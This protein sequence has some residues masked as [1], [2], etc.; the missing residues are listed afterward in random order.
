MAD[1]LNISTPT[2]GNTQTQFFVKMTKDG[3]VIE[4]S[5]V[6]T[7]KQELDQSTMELEYIPQAPTEQEK[8]NYALGLPEIAGLPISDDLKKQV[9]E[10]YILKPD[11]EMPVFDPNKSRVHADPEYFFKTPCVPVIWT[12]KTGTL[13]EAVSE[14]EAYRQKMLRSGKWDLVVTVYKQQY[15]V[16]EA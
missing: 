3:T 1:I 10:Q 8:I 15:N 9:A 2:P 12:W 11:F 6:P 16:Q 4:G 13:E 7:G 5:S 14:A